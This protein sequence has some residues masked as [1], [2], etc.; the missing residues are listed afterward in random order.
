MNFHNFVRLRSQSRSDACSV[1]SYAQEHKN[2]W[3]SVVGSVSPLVGRTVL[4]VEDEPLI[5]LELH[6]TLHEAGASIL[7]AT[8]I[9]DA[10]EFIAYAKIS[11]AIVDVNLGGHDCSSVCDALTK[12]SIPFMFYTGYSSAAPLLAWPRAPAVGKPAEGS[13]MVETIVQLLPSRNIIEATS[14]L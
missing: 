4:I 12:R 11:A 1:Q 7:S 2:C 9:K 3:G 6:N 10:L 8:N 14:A 13:T 5:A